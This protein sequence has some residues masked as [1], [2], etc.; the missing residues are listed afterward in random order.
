M[1]S[2]QKKH[3]HEAKQ[4]PLAKRIVS[5]TFNALASYTLACGLFAL[6]ALLT[7][8]GTLEQ[9]NS[10]I[11]DVQKKYF[12]SFFL[13]H[14]LFGKIPVLLPGVYL[15][16]ILLTINIVLG[17]VIKLRKSPS[18][19]GILISH[20]GIVLLIAG[21]FIKFQLASDG[22]ATLAEGESASEYESYFT[23]EL[24]I[25]KEGT[26]QRTEYLVPEEHFRQA[27]PENR[28]TF[29]HD[30]LPFNVSLTGYHRNSEPVNVNRTPANGELVVDGFYL[31]PT[32]L[33][34]E[35]ERN[36]SGAYAEIT[37][38]A[39]GETKQ[40]LLW[41]FEKMPFAFQQGNDV[42]SVAL[43]KKRYPLPFTVRL[44]KFTHEL[45]PRT[46][47]A[48]IFRSDVTKTEN[49]IAQQHKISMN[50][51]LRHKGYTF[52]QASW[53]PADPAAGRPVMSSF[54]VTKDPADR[55]PLYACIVITVGLL[56]HFGQKLVVYL[57][58]EQKRIQQ[59][60]LA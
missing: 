53:I 26:L 55:I 30:A 54:A 42:W 29:T 6:L 50:E 20:L 27:S 58:R 24:A 34:K 13:V 17:G 3:K 38:K 1:S 36:V 32:P 15:L 45:H 41:G 40:A 47:M 33:E 51:P 8:L 59:E 25:A 31:H 14:N 12:E 23:W 21:G 10:G 22:H 46:Q 4:E 52:Y 43:R 48:K 56:L 18:R 35:A 11:F 60:V 49:G 39:T 7:F 57:R 5:K 28:I 2:K 37:D 44:D 16:L 9:I 19:I